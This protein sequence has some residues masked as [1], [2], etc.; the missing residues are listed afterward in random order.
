[1]TDIPD[2]PSSRRFIKGVKRASFSME[3]VQPVSQ[4]APVTPQP[5]APVEEAAAAPQPIA[6][7]P[8]PVQNEER[9]P[10]PQHTPKPAPIRE[11]RSRRNPVKTFFIVLALLLVFGTVG[12]SVYLYWNSQQKLSALEKAS[13]TVYTEYQ[14]STLVDQVRRHMDLPDETPIVTT[15]TNAASLH[16]EPFYANAVDGDKV[17]VFSKRAI[18]Y[19]PTRDRI[20]EVGFIRPVT[21][22][23]VAEVAPTS[24]SS[25]SPES[26][27]T[28]AGTPAVAGASTSIATPT[29]K[30]LIN[31]QAK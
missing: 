13:P 10:A 23:P 6:T 5:Q 20:V 11:Y 22:T 18:L 30:V 12:T 3:A 7:Q 31:N 28:K 29:P 9:K 2:H 27:S 26:G 17:L 19:D 14:T 24:T 16:Q 1:M 8:P 15:V 21:P 25:A 4:P